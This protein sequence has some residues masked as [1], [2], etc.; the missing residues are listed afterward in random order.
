MNGVITLGEMKG[1]GMT[2]PRRLSPLRAPRPAVD[3]GADCRA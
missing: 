2:M 3:R 1:K